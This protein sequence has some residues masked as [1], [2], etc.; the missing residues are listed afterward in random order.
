M[1]ANREPAVTPSDELVQLRREN[2][3]LTTRLATLEHAHE[4][5]KRRLEEHDAASAAGAVCVPLIES[6]RL[7]TEQGEVYRMTGEGR[8]GE[9]HEAISF[10]HDIG[11]NPHSLVRRIEG[12][13]ANAIRPKLLDKWPIWNPDNWL[14]LQVWIEAGGPKGV[15][16]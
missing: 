12:M 3:E 11:Y 15:H 6:Y 13:A 9:W 1:A 2:Q 5:L 4:T 10:V 8:G 14:H 16:K 7:D